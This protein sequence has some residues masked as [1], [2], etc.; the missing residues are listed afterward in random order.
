MYAFDY[1]DSGI[2][3]QARPKGAKAAKEEAMI[4]AIMETTYMRI[5]SATVQIAK[6]SSKRVKVMEDANNI[7]LFA[8]QVSNLDPAAQRFFAL[9]REIALQQL[10]DDA[11]EMRSRVR[12]A[13]DV[14]DKDHPSIAGNEPVSTEATSLV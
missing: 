11:A 2:V 1:V 9:R 10:E 3:A 4:A 7:A 13:R 5:A 6:A 12:A 8:I 14:E